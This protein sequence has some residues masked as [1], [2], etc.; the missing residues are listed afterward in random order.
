MNERLI[1]ADLKLL[2]RIIKDEDV[3]DSM[4]NLRTTARRAGLVINARRRVRASQVFSSGKFLLLENP[5]DVEPIKYSS[6][7]PPSVVSR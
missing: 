4:F 7:S 2:K 3:F 1:Y 5:E 6:T